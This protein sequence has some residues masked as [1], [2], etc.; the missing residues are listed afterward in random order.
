M[1]PSRTTKEFLVGALVLGVVLLLAVF[2]WLMGALGPFHK[3]VRYD[4]LYA[5]AG[6][7]EVGSPVRV[8]GV[9]V[10]K[11]EKI[12]FL[13]PSAEAEKDRAAIKLTI[14]VS[15]TAAPAVRKDSNF[16]IN[17]AGIIGERYVEI[18]PGSLG[19]EMLP[20]GASV[21]GIDPPRIDQLLSQGYGVFGRIQE[22]LE[23]NEKTL[24]EFLSNTNQLLT[25]ANK[26][27]QGAEKGKVFR[28]VDNLN[29]IAVDVKSLTKSLQQAQ[30]KEFFDQITELVRR[31]HDIDKGAL[32]KFLQEEG[33]RARIF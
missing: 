23:D 16:Y 7:V 27:M 17:M 33:I 10:G 26:M 25:D 30:S 5:F 22:F 4:L 3:E 8:A 24:T 12:E 19:S 32:K 9:K 15:Q 14:G 1:S 11:V 2:G 20:A 21:R 29:S 13:A 18:S 28:L 31:A 6:G